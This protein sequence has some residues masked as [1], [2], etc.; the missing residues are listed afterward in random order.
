MIDLDA[1]G[2]PITTEVDENGNSYNV[3]TLEPVWEANTVTVV[4][5]PGA[6]GTA[7]PEST[8]IALND[9]LIFPAAPDSRSASR[10]FDGWELKKDPARRFAAG[11]ALVFRDWDFV[12][13]TAENPQLV[14]EAA[15][16][17]QR[18]SLLS[19]DTAGGSIVDPFDTTAGSQIN[20]P[21]A[22]YRVG[23]TFTG[24]VDEDGNAVTWPYTMPQQ[25]VTLTATWTVNSYTISFVT[26]EDA[27][28]LDPITVPYGTPLAEIAESIPD[29]VRP[30]YSMYNWVPQ[31]PATMPAE[32]LELTAHWRRS[33]YTL[34]FDANGGKWVEDDGS[35]TTTKDYT[36]YY[37][38]TV[39]AVSAPTRE[40]H[41]FEGWTV[42]YTYVD[43]TIV[44]PDD[45]DALAEVP[46]RMPDISIKFAAKWSEHLWANPDYVWA[47]DYSSVT[48][49]RACIDDDA[50]TETETVNTTAAV[51]KE[52]G[53]TTRGE[54]TYTAEFT[55]P[56]F[57]TRTLTVKNLDA[58]GH[59]W[60]EWV[61]TRPAT[62]AEAG[63]ET[64]TCGRDAEHTMLRSI[65]VVWDAST[66]DFVIPFNV[67]EEEA[68][69]G[70]AA[71]HVEVQPN[72]ESIGPRAFADCPSLRK[73][74][75]PDS[76]DYVDQTA[77]DGCENVLVC[78]GVSAAYL[79]DLNDFDFV[80]ETVD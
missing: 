72:V 47:D 5:E 48:A 43:D 35:E 71:T 56:A 8:T 22:P 7:A 40:G 37:D 79:A 16:S 1:D 11:E 13:G 77:L 65:A 44:P 46:A 74:H 54:T 50:H 15:W 4:Y 10:Y 70:I 80:W 52:P 24:W 34:E 68:F 69:A 55:N 75:I 3:I 67:I 19:F 23:Y 60:G 29:P 20:E 6:Y 41:Y 53:C 42:A 25:G 31:I 9:T 61:V 38:S 45:P 66:A 30:H 78:G 58:L 57:E 32:D 14:F 26:P 39:P 64:C 76:V 73:I 28:Q 62:E 12:S 21:E 63:E 49:T 51:T 17:Q 33:E 18:R 2:S 36:G 59:D 27:T